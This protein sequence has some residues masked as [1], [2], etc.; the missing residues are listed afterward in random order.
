MLCVG[1]RTRPIQMAGNGKRISDVTADHGQGIESGKA[2]PCRESS[3]S[4]KAATDPNSLSQRV[5][6]NSQPSSREM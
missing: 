1:D 5:P 2:K 3:P 6:L 4:S